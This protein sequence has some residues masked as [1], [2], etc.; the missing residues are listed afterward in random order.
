MKSKDKRD[1]ERQKRT[2][3]SIKTILP[4]LK[5]SHKQIWNLFQ[6]TELSTKYRFSFVLHK[7]HIQNYPSPNK[8]VT[9]KKTPQ[10]SPK[11]PKEVTGSK[12]WQVS[13]DSEMWY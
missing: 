1:M 13:V 6:T 9:L 8:F 4:I 3:R 11:S 2:A 5:Q 10:Y 7:N 12:I